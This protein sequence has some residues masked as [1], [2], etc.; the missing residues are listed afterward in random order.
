V[1]GDIRIW[2]WNTDF[3]EAVPPSIFQNHIRCIFK[4]KQEKSQ[5]LKLINSLS[6][7]LFISVLLLILKLVKMFR[8]F[9][10]LIKL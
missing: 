8:V 5:K 3:E 2:P 1:F 9:M 4:D 6:V 7:R 10:V